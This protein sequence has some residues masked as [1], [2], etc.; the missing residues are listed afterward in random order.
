V[1]SVEQQ[2]ARDQVVIREAIEDGMAGPAR[3]EDDLD[4]SFDPRSMQIH[5]A[6]DQFDGVGA[7]FGIRRRLHLLH[8]FFDVLKTSPKVY[9]IVMLNRL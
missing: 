5:Q 1:Q 8:E 2:E 3:F 6:L 7:E 9:F 4:H